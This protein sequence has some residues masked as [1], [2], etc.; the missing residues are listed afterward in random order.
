MRKRRAGGRRKFSW[1][2]AEL[3]PTSATSAARLA[4][5]RMFRRRLRSADSGDALTAVWSPARSGTAPLGAE[6]E[7]RTPSTAV[8]TPV[9]ATSPTSTSLA[10]ARRRSSGESR[11]SRASAARAPAPP[12]GVGAAPAARNGQQRDRVDGA[13]AAPGRVDELA[14]LLLVRDLGHGR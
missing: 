3:T 14:A 11:P 1:A 6:R 8:A 2:S 10:P 9:T 12:G 5:P 7:K 4:A 13:V